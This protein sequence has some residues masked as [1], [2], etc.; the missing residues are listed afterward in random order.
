MEGTVP[1]A[2]LRESEELH[3]I[4]LLSMSDAV[5][6]TDNEGVFTF[7]CPNV[8]VIFG[9]S[10]EEVRSM[11]RISR[12]PGRELLEPGQ[13]ADAGEVWNI[14]HEIEAKGGV[15][16]LKDTLG[17]VSMRERARMV[18]AHLLVSSKPGAGTTVEIHLPLDPAQVQSA[19]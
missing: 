10:H 3:R 11:D 15:G 8:D 17:L 19:V 4:T 16:H 18:R 6:I 2:E 14:E 13:L 7:I 5:F 9:Y 1:A 12:L